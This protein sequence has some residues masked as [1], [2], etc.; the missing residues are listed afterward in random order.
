MFDNLNIEVLGLKIKFGKED[1][2]IISN[3]NPPE[4]MLSKKLFSVVQD[5]KIIYMLLGDLNSKLRSL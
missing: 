4:K 5:L 2:M 3:Y 1:I